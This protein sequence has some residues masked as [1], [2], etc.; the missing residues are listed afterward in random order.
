M[1]PRYLSKRIELLSVLFSNIRTVFNSL[2]KNYCGRFN[3]VLQRKDLLGLVQIIEIVQTNAAI[4][5][6]FPFL[7]ENVPPPASEILLVSFC[8]FHVIHV[9]YSPACDVFSCVSLSLRAPSCVTNVNV[10]VRRGQT[11]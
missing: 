9:N 2:V 1:I 6:P 3:I 5:I 10:S 4:Y 8:L 11:A 7:R